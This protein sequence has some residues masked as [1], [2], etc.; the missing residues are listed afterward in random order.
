MTIQAAVF[1]IHL[2][3]SSV[4]LSCAL[5]LL[6][7]FLPPTPAAPVPKSDLLGGEDPPSVSPTACGV[8]PAVDCTPSS[9]MATGIVERAEGAALPEAVS[10]RP[11]TKLTIESM[12]RVIGWVGGLASER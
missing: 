11:M 7:P 4:S 9:G 8:A 5:P 3:T 10:E 1:S 2:P 6:L 12:G